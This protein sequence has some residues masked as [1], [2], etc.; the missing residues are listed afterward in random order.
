MNVVNSGHN[1]ENMKPNI[2]A[3]YFIW[4]K[5]SISNIK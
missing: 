3:T 4:T 2:F 5:A 1:L